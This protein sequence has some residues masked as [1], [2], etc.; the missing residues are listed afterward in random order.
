MWE[1]NHKEGWALKNWCLQTVV[2]LKPLKSPL[3]SKEI[4]PVNPKESQ[5][6]IFTGGTDA[7]AESP[8]LWPPEAK[9]QLTG[10]DPDVGKHWRQEKAVTEDKTVGWHHWLGG[11]ESE[12]TLADSEGQGSLVCCSPWDSKELDMTEQ[13][14]DNIL[15]SSI[16][17]RDIVIP[18]L[19]RVVHVWGWGQKI[20]WEA[21]GNRWACQQ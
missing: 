7:E 11:P 21:L 4:R 3:D 6:C 8:K 20:L 10:K 16:W 5:P 17:G 9:S 13:L 12:Q 1:V 14:D 19:W 18:I 15:I 2:L